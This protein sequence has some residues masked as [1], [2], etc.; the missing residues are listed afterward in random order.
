MSENRKS[1]HRSSEKREVDVTPSKHVRFGLN[2][3][4][5]NRNDMEIT[6]IE[7]S[8]FVASWSR[9]ENR[10]TVNFDVQKAKTML[11]YNFKFGFAVHLSFKNLF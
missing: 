5:Q 11:I 2:M 1:L 7:K 8:G 3:A 4:Q 9:H 10:K 6:K